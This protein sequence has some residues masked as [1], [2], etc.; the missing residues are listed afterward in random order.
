MGGVPG[1]EIMKTF[2]VHIPKTGGTSLRHG[3]AMKYVNHKDPFPVDRCP[4]RFTFAHLLPCQFSEGSQPFVDN[5][6]KITFVRD[7]YDRAASIYVY[8]TQGRKPFVQYFEEIEEL[9]SKKSDLG[10]VFTPQHCWF[11]GIEYDFVGRYETIDADV[12]KAKEISDCPVVRFPHMNKSPG[13]KPLEEY[14]RD[15]KHIDIV[16]RMFKKDFELLGYPM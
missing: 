2:L 15:S 16:Q 14:Y 6:F 13:R 5:A 7:P 4:E 1:K 11:E 10:R 3:L 12:M 9:H 8:H